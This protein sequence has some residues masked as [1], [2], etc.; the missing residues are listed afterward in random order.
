LET[1]DSEIGQKKN[2]WYRRRSGI[3]ASAIVLTLLAICVVVGFSFYNQSGTGGEPISFFCHTALGDGAFILAVGINITDGMDQA[4]AVA[5]AGQVYSR[6]C[7]SRGE[8][9]LRRAEPGTNGTW[10]V[11]YCC[12]IDIQRPGCTNPSGHTIVSKFYRF[13]INPFDRT[14]EYG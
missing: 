12:L 14:V 6:I 1:I 7:D 4:E 13:I 9:E 2:V 5:V 8:V 3:A 11:E 10:T